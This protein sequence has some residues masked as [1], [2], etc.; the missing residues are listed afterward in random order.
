VPGG[1][2]IGVDLGGTKLLAGAVD[3]R[4]EVHHRAHRL[5]P[6]TD[7]AAVLDAIVETIDAA[8]EGAGATCGRSASGSPR[9]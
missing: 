7:R 2:V 6:S 8:R 4:L 5:A 1:C 3:E 9:S